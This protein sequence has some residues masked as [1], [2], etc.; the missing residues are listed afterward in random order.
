[1]N[2]LPSPNKPPC[3]SYPCNPGL[4]RTKCFGLQMRFKLQ[5][6]CVCFGILVFRDQEARRGITILLGIIGPNQQEKVGL[7]LHNGDREEWNMCEAQVTQLGAFW[8]SYAQLQ[9]W[10]DECSNAVWGRYGYQR[11]R[12]LRMKDLVMPPRKQRW[13]LRVRGIWMESVRGKQVLVAAPRLTAAMGT[14]VCSADLSLLSFLSEPWGS[15][16]SPCMCREVELDGT[17]CAL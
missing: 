7:L 6:L 9:L 14:L 17:G 10:L 4:C 1:M 3:A 5:L 12:P 8:Y 2:H 11:L 13:Q 16:C 15:C